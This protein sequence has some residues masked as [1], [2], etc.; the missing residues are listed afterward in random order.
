MNLNLIKVGLQ[1]LINDE[2]YAEEAQKAIAEIEQVQQLAAPDHIFNGECYVLHAET[3]SGLLNIA[4]YDAYGKLFVEY[5]GNVSLGDYE[6]IVRDQ[7]ECDYMPQSAIELGYDI[8][9]DLYSE[10]EH[11]GC[12]CP[13][14]TFNHVERFNHLKNLC[15][16][17][18]DHDVFKQ[19]YVEEYG[20][21]R[22]SELFA[23][24]TYN[25]ILE[26][27]VDDD[28]ANN[29]ADKLTSVFF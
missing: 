3:V 6:Q 25:L 2:G 9:H 8:I 21:E 22:T 18:T 13:D 15:K 23:E 27:G 17:L 7:Y 16:W 11:Y 24:H 4:T 26:A 5:N 12:H 10:N 29:L 14:G 20:L 19:E 28:V 1:K